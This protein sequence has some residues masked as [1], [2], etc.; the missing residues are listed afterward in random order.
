MELKSLAYYAQN[1]SKIKVVRM[2]HRLVTDIP[3][4]TNASFGMVFPFF[5]ISFFWVHI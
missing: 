5:Y 1:K 4:T 2:L 3:E